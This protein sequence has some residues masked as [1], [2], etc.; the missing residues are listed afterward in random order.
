MSVIRGFG[1][2]GAA[3]TEEQR[4]R[5]APIAEVAVALCAHELDIEYAQ[6]CIDVVQ[7]AS[8][9]EPFPF[10]RGRVEIWAGAI[11]HMVAKRNGAF[12]AWF[13]P[14]IFAG[15]IGDMVG[16][17]HASISTRSRELSGLLGL[18]DRSEDPR[19]L[20]AVRHDR[21]LIRETVDAARARGD[22][23]LDALV[24]LVEQQDAYAAAQ[25]VEARAFVPASQHVLR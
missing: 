2:D 19:Y 4:R 12:H 22:S 21:N 11:V 17:S 23:P 6:L 18:G 7:D 16:A 3:L 10:E 13:G 15:D 1:I 24:A 20:R 9:L 8:A 5:V 14:G 25:A